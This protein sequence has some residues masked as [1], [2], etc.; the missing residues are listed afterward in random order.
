[1]RMIRLAC[2][3]AVS[4][5]AAAA[6]ALSI[7]CPDKSFPRAVQGKIAVET[8]S[9]KQRESFT[10]LL[11][12][13]YHREALESAEIQVRADGALV[14]VPVAVVYSALG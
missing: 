9:S 8:D 5:Y 10:V 14:R 1:M 4:L 7:V 13:T 12:E 6:P 2:L 3:L 11:P